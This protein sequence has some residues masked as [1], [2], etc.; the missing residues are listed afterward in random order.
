MTKLPEWMET[1]ESRGLEGGKKKEKIAKE[2][3]RER[4]GKGEKRKKKRGSKEGFAC[5]HGNE[6]ESLKS[7]AC[8]ATASRF[9][10]TRF[11]SSRENA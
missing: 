6:K 7:S 1:N 8:L 4:G 10:V 11:M 2:E 5:A 9:S 3:P